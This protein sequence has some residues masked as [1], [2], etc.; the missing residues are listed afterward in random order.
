[1]GTLEPGWH[2]VISY[3]NLCIESLLWTE[4][5]VIPPIPMY[6]LK[7]KPPGPQKLTMFE[8]SA[9]KGVMKVKWGNMGGH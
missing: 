1:M 5:C 2:D 3:V 9:F 4:V 8:D 6:M 7:T